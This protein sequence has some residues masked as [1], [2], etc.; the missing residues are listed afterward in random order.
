MQD[1][2]V[3]LQTIT[4]VTVLESLAYKRIKTINN[5]QSELNLIQQRIAQ[6]E[7]PQDDVASPIDPEVT[8]EPQ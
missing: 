2:P 8:D 7:V 1:Q 5:A 6:L 4:D 3:D